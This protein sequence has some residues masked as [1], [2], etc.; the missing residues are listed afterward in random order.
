MTTEL[1][2]NDVKALEIVPKDTTIQTA[3]IAKEVKS[4]M[5]KKEKKVLFNGQRYPELDDWQFV[6]AF[7]GLKTITES[8]PVNMSG[9]DGFKAKARV[10]DGA[11]MEVGGA[12]SFCMKDEV[13]WK[14]KP[15]FQLSSMAQTRA[16]SKALSNLLR[17]V[18][19]LAGYATTP[20]E[21]MV[22]TVESTVEKKSYMPVKKEVPAVKESFTTED[23]EVV[24]DISPA[25]E[26]NGPA[27]SAEVE[28]VQEVFEGQI[29]PKQVVRLI[30]IAKNV[31]LDEAGLDKHIK[32]KYGLDS[33][34]KLHWK[35]MKEIEK[36]LEG[37]KE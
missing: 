22:G 12:E 7:Y 17:P 4:Y 3:T 31:G 36:T 37:M 8:Q 24:E 16:A 23:A 1:A 32:S 14:S 21:E 11:G 35:Q 5:S 33:K 34:K 27:E 13:N 19:K 25:D 15:L 30:M 6:A 29:T 2:V 20:A 10:I 28:K 9:V 26:F 18:M